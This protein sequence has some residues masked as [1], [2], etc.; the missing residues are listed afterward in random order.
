[1]QNNYATFCMFCDNWCVQPISELSFACS[2]FRCYRSLLSENHPSQVTVLSSEKA[3]QSN[4]AS[5]LAGSQKGTFLSE[6]ANRGLNVLFFWKFIV[7]LD[8]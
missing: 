6:V 8:N 4:K 1:M 3:L 7:I 5:L 2:T